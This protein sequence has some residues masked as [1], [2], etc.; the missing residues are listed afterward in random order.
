MI[1]VI[2]ALIPCTLM[3]F[4]NTGLQANTAMHELGLGTGGRLDNFILVGEDNVINTDLRYDESAGEWRLGAQCAVPL[5]EIARALTARSF[6]DLERRA[7]G[8][9][10]LSA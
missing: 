7:D 8:S 6:P 1:L 4:W 2:V 3:A 5:S 9:C 10:S